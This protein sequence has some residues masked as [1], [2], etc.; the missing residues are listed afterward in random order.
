M[1]SRN[2]TKITIKKGLDLPIAGEPE[3]TIEP[4]PPVARVGVLSDDYPG[5][6]LEPQVR[7]GESVRTGDPLLVHKAF[8]ELV[9]PSP[10]TGVVSAIHWGPRRTPL[11]VT[12]ELD[13]TSGPQCQPARPGDEAA[14]AALDA[15]RIRS[16]LLSS[17]LWTALRTRPFS[18]IPLPDAMADALFVTAMDSNPLAANP[19]IV[20]AAHEEDF[21]CGLTVLAKLTDGPVYVCYEPAAEI[22]VPAGDRYRVAEFAGPHPAGLVGT[23]ISFLEPVDLT[24]SVWYL[25]YQDVIAIGRFFATGTLCP[26]RTISLAGPAVLRPR[27]IR[28][29][30]G[31]SLADLVN[32]ELAPGDCRVISGSLWS[33]RRA[34]G[35]A[36]FLGRHHTQVTV[37]AEAQERTL[38]GW[39]KPGFDKFSVTRA[40]AS[41]LRRQG[42]RRFAINTSQQGSPRAMVPIGSYE[43]VMPLAIQPT[44]LL[45]ALLVRDVETALALG[46]LELDEEDLALCSFVCPSKYEFGPALRDVLEQIA[47]EG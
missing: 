19:R 36:A 34:A 43:R 26:V 6:K 24:R 25:G 32:D 7:E 42:A 1:P 31:V 37:L 9:V 3:Q 21:R 29:R 2:T 23:H 10:G 14:L 22:P 28:T 18:H 45:R 39:C 15:V 33:G 30:L 47:K 40:F 20:L 35:W 44:A 16:Q 5:L 46:C 27:L 11:A 17:G 4:G 8:T 38:L 41:G 13:E 12:V